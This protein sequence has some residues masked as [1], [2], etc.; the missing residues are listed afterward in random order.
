MDAE[1]TAAAVEPSV[2]RE[3]PSADDW[4]T[5]SVP[6]RPARFADADAVA[7]RTRLPTFRAASRAL[8]SLERCYASARIWIDDTFIAETD[9]VVEPIRAVYDP[10]GDRELLVECRAPRDAFGGMDD[11]PELPAT[12]RVPAITAE[13]Q[14][15]AVPPTAVVDI[16][17]EP[18]PRADPP[19]F[20]VTVTVDSEHGVADQCRLSVRPEGFRGAG[21]MG[22]IP[23]ECSAGERASASTTVEISDAR[24]WWPRDLGPQHRYAIRASLDS[25]ER[26]TTAGFCRVS[27]EGET[28]AVNG[29]RYR[30]RGIA[31]GPTVDPQVAVKRALDANATLLR[32]H[33]HVPSHALHRLCDETGLLVWQDLPLTGSVS[34]E[35]DRGR[36]LASALGTQY[37]HHP[38]IACYGGHDDPVRPFAGRLGGGSV[39]RTRFRWR[40]WRTEVDRATIERI[41]AA[42]P[43]DAVA[44]PVSGQPGTA[45]DAAHLYP[46]WQYGTPYLLD[47]LLD[48]YPALGRIV[49]EFGAGSLL[50]A[51]G[52]SVPGLDSEAL[53]AVADPADPASTQRAQARIIKRVAEGLRR[54]GAALSVAYRL[55][56]PTPTGG[57]GLCQADGTP[58]PALGALETAFEPVLAVLDGPPTGTVTV[59]VLNDRPRQQS[60]TL[61]WA[62]GHRSGQLDVEVDPISRA[63]A[64]AITIADGADRVTLALTVG[65]RTVKNVYQI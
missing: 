58:K 34:P 63:D 59:S 57:M 36:E 26:T 50:D 28:L 27:D 49:G 35:G 42:F 54:R 55:T 32:A 20:H 41:A 38:S 23:I 52:E 25:H 3:P 33:A 39:G 22:R 61:E 15:T 21:T 12:D 65:D 47:W 2:G 1:W 4:T 17:V 10:A 9:S 44:L 13:P 51:T 7:Y 14:V 56:D 16:D 24:E 46:G 43:D 64:G 62:A 30:P 48:R 29:Q 45:P 60:G 53:A 8:L 37:G 5:V 6:G 31:I 19:A 18:R 11:S 40:T